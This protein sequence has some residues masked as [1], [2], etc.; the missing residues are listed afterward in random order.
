MKKL[1]IQTPKGLFTLLAAEIP[2]LFGR[3]GIMA[4]LAL[5]MTQT[6][7]YSDKVAF[8]TYSTFLMLTYLTPLLGGFIADRYLT[9][10]KAIILGASIMFIGNCL[11]MVPDVQFLYIGLSA[12]ALGIGFFSPSLA[13][14][15]DHLY[16]GQESKR[17]SGFVLY[18]IA[19]NVGALLGPVMCGI[20]G[21]F[22]GYNYAFGLCALAILLGL[23]IFIVGSARFSINDITRNKALKLDQIFIKKPQLSSV[24]LTVVLI[25]LVV[26]I[27]IYQAAGLLVLIGGIL[28]IVIM[29][30]LLIQGSRSERIDL[31]YI[32]AST[33]FASIFFMLL[34]QSGS[35][36][37]LFIER[38]IDRHVLGFQLSPAVFYSLNPVFMLLLGSVVIKLLAKVTGKHFKQSAFLKFAYAM[39]IF[40]LGMA[41]FVVATERA[42]FLGQV[43][44]GYVVLA[45]MI[46]PVAEL[47]IMPVAISLITRLASRHRVGLMFAVYSFGLAVGSY[48]NGVFSN[49]ADIG[50]PV[51]T[52]VGEQHASI[53]YQ[54]VFLESVYIL[55]F[56]GLLALICY[57][58]FGYFSKTAS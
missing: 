17:D 37:N 12:V 15:I 47:F 9:Y 14:M 22:V 50:F 13:A 35:T 55:V 39:F 20:L 53:I 52:L 18:Y 56:M 26:A 4:L 28:V 42:Q 43:S 48:F 24:I 10:P 45:Y 44:S 23:I 7:H 36:F 32:I 31:L 1:L 38:L 40:A 57:K 34:A 27:F 6:L 2:D 51:N 58:L 46:M 16:Q 8:F 49:K 11:M 30:H 29:S 41:V 54:H 21:S 19:K 3:F 5:Y 33:I 25:P